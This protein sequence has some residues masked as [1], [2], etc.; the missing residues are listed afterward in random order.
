MATPSADGRRARGDRTRHEVARQAALSATVH[1][2]DGITVGSLAAQTGH[3]KSG[4]LTVFANR[5]AIQI[6]AV[7][8]A[9]ALYLHHVIEPSL[10][11]APGRPRLRALLDH[12]LAYLR[13]RVFPGGCFITTTTVEYGRREGPV[14]DAVRDLAREWL[15]LLENELVGAGSSTPADDAFRIDAY[16]RAAHTRFQIFGDETVLD[17]ARRL[18]WDVI[19]R[20]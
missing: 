15:L 11:S 16:L 4:I 9:R 17:R 5:E 2:L 13:E 12:W 10:Q 7:A 6:A 1:G 20:G 18:A 8:E 19:E 3:S 14:A